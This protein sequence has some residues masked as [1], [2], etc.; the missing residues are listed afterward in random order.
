MRGGDTVKAGLGELDEQTHGLVVHAVLRVV[1]IDSFNLDAH[2]SAAIGILG[3]ELTQ[4]ACGHVEVV[5]LE[6]LKGFSSS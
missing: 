1:E 2:A 6:G 5:V 3:E 4:V